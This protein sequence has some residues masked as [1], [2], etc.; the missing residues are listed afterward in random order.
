MPC[1]LKWSLSLR[2]PTK[3]LHAPLLSPTRAKSRDHVTL[4]DLITQIV[5]GKE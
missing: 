3:T 2:S 5:M 1:F 4:L